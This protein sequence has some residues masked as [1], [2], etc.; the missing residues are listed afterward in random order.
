VAA[1]ARGEESSET[2]EAWLARQEKSLVRAAAA[3]LSN[4]ERGV[5]EGEIERDL[6]PYRGRLPEAVVTQVRQ[7]GLARRFLERW[8]LPRLT[9]FHGE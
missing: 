6:A 3:A 9:L 1:A 7:E 8:G 4:S 2:L 5:I